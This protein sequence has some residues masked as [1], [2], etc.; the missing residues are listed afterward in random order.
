VRTIASVKP[1]PAA[2]DRSRKGRGPAAVI[3]LS[4]ARRPAWPTAIREHGY[5]L[6]QDYCHSLRMVISS[7]LPAGN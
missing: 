4:L 1:P 3:L 6:C 2:N 7:P 5:E